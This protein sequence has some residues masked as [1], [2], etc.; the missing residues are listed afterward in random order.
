[1]QLLYIFSNIY[2]MKTRNVVDSL[3]GLFIFPQIAVAATCIPGQYAFQS[4]E[5]TRCETCDIGKYC[6][7]GETAKDCAS[8]GFPKSAAG[9]KSAEEC[10]KECEAKDGD[11]T[12]GTGIQ[13][14][15]T[16]AKCEISSSSC[17]KNYTY[18][19]NAP[20]DKSN[21]F[22]GYC[23]KTS[24]DCS[25]L[26]NQNCVV[27]AADCSNLADGQWQGTVINEAKIKT[28]GTYDLTQCQCQ[29]TGRS[30]NGSNFIDYYSYS[31]TDN[32]NHFVQEPGHKYTITSCD[33]GYCIFV[34]TDVCRSTPAGYYHTNDGGT[35]CVPCPAGQTSK[36]GSTSQ[37][38]C[39]YTSET[40][41]CDKNGCISLQMIDVK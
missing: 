36:S 15:K 13:Y 26:L 39:H 7:D 2:N 41:F 32:C 1:M 30:E 38:D 24:E 16:D 27:Y 20:S 40:Q 18:V 35:D 23:V 10:Y 17:I 25:K 12:V 29:V 11:T 22:K 14:N 37:S 19:Q 34:P 6:P 33:A 8:T 4:D 28:D 5:S 9:A 21:T 3:L 31:T